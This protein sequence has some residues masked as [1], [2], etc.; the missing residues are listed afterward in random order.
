[1][2][3][4]LDKMYCGLIKRGDIFACEHQGE[5]KVV[6]VLQDQVL[7]SSLPTVVCALV[8]FNKKDGE[9]FANEILLRDTEMWLDQD[10]ICMLHKI[11]TID[12]RLMYDKKAELPAERLEQIYQA[13]DANLGR[14]RD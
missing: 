8:E 4:D 1:M 10:G 9:V 12:R 3:Y 2:E 6:V 11:V 13:L 5:E 14:F 7:N